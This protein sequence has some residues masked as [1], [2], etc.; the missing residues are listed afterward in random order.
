MNT[1]YYSD[2]LDIMKKHIEDEFVDLICLD[3]LNNT[4]IAGRFEYQFTKMSH[5]FAK[6]RIRIEP[7]EQLFSSPIPL[8]LPNT[9]IDPYKI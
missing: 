5:A 3:I 1:L 6:P 8:Y 4:S 2:N 7:P 9:T